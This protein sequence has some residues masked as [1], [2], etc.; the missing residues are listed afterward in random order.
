M[1]RQSFINSRVLSANRPLHLKGSLAFASTKMFL[2]VIGFGVFGV[3]ANSINQA[4]AQTIVVRPTEDAYVID[5][6]QAETLTTRP[7]G[8]AIKMA[9]VPAATVIRARPTSRT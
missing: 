3:I 1:S 6:D 4:T 2:F 8:Q 5:S 9:L 7:S